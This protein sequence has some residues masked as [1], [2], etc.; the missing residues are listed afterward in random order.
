M[1]TNNPKKNFFSMFAFSVAMLF[2][3]KTIHCFNKKPLLTRSEKR[4]GTIYRF[5]TVKC[6]IDALVTVD[7]LTSNA[8]LNSFN[9]SDTGAVSALQPELSIE[10]H[11]WGYVQLLI[12]F[13]KTGTTTP[14]DVNDI[15]TKGIS[16]GGNGKDVKLDVLSNSA[17]SF[18]VRM[19]TVNRNAY[20]MNIKADVFLQRFSDVNNLP[21]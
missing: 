7:K 16:F 17:N 1:K 2:S 3:A 18:K 15:P 20:P 12:Q 8:S 4:Q 11:C 5:P 13:V 9:L 10:P 21:S 6:D 14:V 19:Y